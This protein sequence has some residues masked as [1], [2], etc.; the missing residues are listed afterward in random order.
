MNQFPTAYVQYI[1]AVTFPSL[2]IEK[3]KKK[4]KNAVIITL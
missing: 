4:Y 1:K 2:S 3:D